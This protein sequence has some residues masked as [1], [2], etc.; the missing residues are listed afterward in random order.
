MVCFFG[1]A[2]HEVEIDE[3]VDV[4][5]VVVK[6]YTFVLLFDKTQRRIDENVDVV[7]VVDMVGTTPS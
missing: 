4:V 1:I 3:I 2:R 6:L 5:V 7:V